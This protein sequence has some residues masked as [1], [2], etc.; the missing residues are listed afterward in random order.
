[1]KR[2]DACCGRAPGDWN[3]LDCSLVDNCKYVKCSFRTSCS[4]TDRHDSLGDGS[5]DCYTL[6]DGGKGIAAKQLKQALFGFSF[7][8][9]QDSLDT[10]VHT[11]AASSV[12]LLV[13]HCDGL[14]Y[15]CKRNVIGWSGKAIAPI[16]PFTCLDNVGTNQV[17]QYS[18]HDDGMRT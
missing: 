17:G 15:L 7:D 13:R 6:Q 9:V 8:L 1:M 11:A 5:G 14:V 18:S 3:S 2:N 10:R 12:L 4:I 16:T